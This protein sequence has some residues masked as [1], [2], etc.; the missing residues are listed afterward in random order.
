[1]RK[2][3]TAAQTSSEKHTHQISVSCANVSVLFMQA[4]AKVQTFSVGK[5]RYRKGKFQVQSDFI[6]GVRQD[7]SPSYS[8]VIGGM[9]KKTAIKFL[10]AYTEELRQE[11]ELVRAGVWPRKRVC[12]FRIL[13]AI[14][15]AGGAA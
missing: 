8:S 14:A 1:M 2:Q 6:Q 5:D 12:Q 11:N 15:K 4:D 3:H 7:G 9:T 13:K 10:D